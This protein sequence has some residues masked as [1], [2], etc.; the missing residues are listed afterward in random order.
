MS[1]TIKWIPP[2]V[3]G[4]HVILFAVLTYI[5]HRQRM[6][7]VAFLR[8]DHEKWEAARDELFGLLTEE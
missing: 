1:E 3:T 6:R 4:L 8:E 2:I 5:G 7:F